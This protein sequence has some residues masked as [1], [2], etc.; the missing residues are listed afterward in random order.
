MHAEKK[1]HLYI[2]QTKGSD[3]ARNLPVEAAKARTLPGDI[4]FEEAY[5]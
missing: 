1:E 3:A 2:F 4:S 5:C